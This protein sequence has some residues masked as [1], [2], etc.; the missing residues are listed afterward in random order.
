MN[1]NN[2]NNSGLTVKDITFI[3]VPMPDVV[4]SGTISC[5]QIVIE[6]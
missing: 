5:T 4:F 6:M 3:H 2:C 1:E